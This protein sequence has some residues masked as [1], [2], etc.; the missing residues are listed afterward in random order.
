MWCEV[1]FGHMLLIETVNT[2]EQKK[3]KRKRYPSMSNNHNKNKG[4]HN[5]ILDIEE[6][7][8]KT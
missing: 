1:N 7:D 6:I 5:I 4:G 8:L 3:L 2:K